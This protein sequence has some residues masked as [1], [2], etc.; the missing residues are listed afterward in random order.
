MFDI[1]TTSLLPIFLVIAL[2]KILCRSGFLPAAFFAG[3]NRLAF[4]VSL[5]ALLFS[6]IATSTVEGG[7]ALR[8]T[9]VVLAATMAVILLAYLVMGPLKLN[10]PA[11]GSFVQA[12]MRGNLAYIGLP[13]I[14]YSLSQVADSE[15]VETTAMLVLAP[16]VPVYNIISVIVLLRGAHKDKESPG[17][18]SLIGKVLANPLL[19]ACLLGLLVA[20]AGWHIPPLLLRTLNPLSQTALP[21]ALLAIGAALSRQ[22]IKGGAMP[23]FV[24]S[25]LK[26][27]VAPAFGFLIARALDL[28][29]METR[30]ALILLAC[31]TAVASYV[32]AEQM[33]ADETMAGNTIVVSTLLSFLALAVVLVIPL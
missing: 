11:Q 32:M 21:L 19:I 24:A 28:P 9:L 1:I 5:P 27:A 13:V 6:R 31:P 17:L 12:A 4:Y 20:A 29:A 7:P 15:S 23:A 16:T 22:G 3:L 10:G 2:G 18:G 25:L 26:V 33:G 30:M 14:V 8:V